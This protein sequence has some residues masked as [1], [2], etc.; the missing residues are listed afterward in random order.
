ME[1]VILEYR[2]HK[3]EQEIIKIRARI[4]LQRNEYGIRYQ[5]DLLHYLLKT[6]LELKKQLLTKDKQFTF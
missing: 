1:S 6:Q 3:L 5:T 2:I 4:A